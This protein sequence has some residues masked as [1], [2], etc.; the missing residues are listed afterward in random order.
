MSQSQHVIRIGIVEEMLESFCLFN[1]T[2]CFLLCYI[3]V[4]LTEHCNFYYLTKN[5]L[6][7]TFG[8]LI[9]AG[10]SADFILLLASVQVPLGS[11]SIA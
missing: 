10:N 4:S 7:V 2:H 6:R 9:L 5:S 8:V 11:K 3:S 1:N